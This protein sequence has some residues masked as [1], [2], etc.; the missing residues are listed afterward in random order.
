MTTKNKG[1]LKKIFFIFAFLLLLAVVSF[2]WLLKSSLPMLE[3]EMSF[4]QLHNPVNIERDKQGLVTITAENR[5]DLA[6]ASGFVH[7]Q[8]RFFQMDLMRRRAA[9]ELS[10]ILGKA[11][12]E[13]DKAAR[14]HRF[15]VRSKEFVAKFSANEQAL[16][17]AYA[18]GVNAGLKQLTVKPF[19]YYI[20]GATPRPWAIEDSLLV[21]YGMY[22]SLQSDNGLN[23][24]QAYLLEKSLPKNL[25][26][27]LLSQR[28]DWDVP[29][30]KDKNAV[31]P[32]PLPLIKNTSLKASAS[33][34]NILALQKT[35]D[36]PWGVIG[37]NNWAV[38]GQ[39]TK[40]G[41]GMLANDMHLGIRVPNTWFR[42]R[43]KLSDK[44]LDVN[45]V[46][47]PGT[48]VIVVGS[49][50]FVA[51]GFTNTSADWGDLILLK[52]KPDDNKKYLTPAGYKTFQLFSEPIKIKGEKPQPFTVRE[53]IWGPVVKG[54]SKDLMAYNWVAHYAQGANIGLLKMEQVKSVAEGLSLAD[55]MGIPAQNAMLVD[56]FGNIGWTV[57][58]AIP[59]RRYQPDFKENQYQ[60]PQDWSDGKMAWDGWLTAAEYPKV[61]NPKDYRLWTAN[62]RVTTGK[63]LKVMGSGRF[64]HPARAKQIR[65]DL[66]ALSDA[67]KEQDFLAIQL[68]DR[69]IFL[70]RWQQLLKK[71]LTR[72]ADKKWQPY[73]EF[74]ASWGGRA[75][76]NS[77]GYRLVK[78]FRQ[79]VSR[80]IFARLTKVCR[81]Q[82]PQCNIYQASRQLENPLWT[83]VSTRDKQWLEAGYE[84]WD[85]FF[86]QMATKAFS[87]T[88]KGKQSLVSYSW[89]ER[90]SLQ[91]VHPL[92]RFVPG[93]GLL[94]DMPN[95]SVH[96]DRDMPNVAAP[97]FGASERLVVSP[98][99][100]D[101]GILHMP[102]SQA[103][104][105]LSPYYGKG[106]EDWVK[107]VASPLLPGKT[108]WKLLLKPK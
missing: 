64:A 40:S 90:N 104:N 57:F 16:F 9:G 81:A 7:A 33:A 26:S 86:L 54:P 21:S 85:A 65:D 78:E 71:L 76:I 69:A 45:G 62:N 92:S 50:T 74:I 22:F 88:L 4:K 67:V 47:L 49:N 100:E 10:E 82:F 23:E 3:G 79:T 68:D 24:W 42:L 38:A 106:H 31:Q 66:F 13:V 103:G 60:R 53:S 87:R 2:Y 34:E 41:A 35:Q 61:V 108:Q 12:L 14:V 95:E 32:M 43:L 17:R 80:N 96:G 51:W 15:R 25:S 46:S 8:E 18:E 56:R 70:S 30:E 73:L 91:I 83:I 105:P 63:D 28:S 48:P 11:T 44:S 72:T 75:A 94:T 37:S 6:F 39:L 5:N 97:R 101:K 77:V 99:H 89:G 102:T 1:W 84:N 19:E 59:K 27:F 58:G 55:K 20:L 52:I 29:L 98:G 93:L 107:G 36:D